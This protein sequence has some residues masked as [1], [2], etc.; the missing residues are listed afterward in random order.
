MFLFSLTDVF[1]CATTCFRIRRPFLLH[2]PAEQH[3]S[4]RYLAYRLQCN[5]LLWRRHRPDFE[6]NYHTWYVSCITEDSFFSSRSP[7]QSHI[8]PIMSSRAAIWIPKGQIMTLTPQ[9]QLLNISRNIFYIIFSAKLV[10]R[11][12]QIIW[13]QPNIRLKGTRSLNG[14][15][16]SKTAEKITG[17]LFI[18]KF[19]NGIGRPNKMHSWATCGPLAACL[20]PMVR[21]KKGIKCFVS[22][23]VL[24]C[25]EC[26]S[27]SGVFSFDNS[28]TD[29]CRKL[30]RT[31]QDTDAGI[32]FYRFTIILEELHRG[33]CHPW[34]TRI[35]HSLLSKKLIF[36]QT[37]RNAFVYFVECVQKFSHSFM[38]RR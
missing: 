15:E 13:R 18:W 14:R 5:G 29:C 32:L 38:C 37:T 23:G 7:P 33:H 6:T 24:V 16:L 3:H 28:S 35:L 1:H 26:W 25:K 30:G 21:V 8:S 27:I 10:V 9:S 17:I 34:A 12:W 4:L 19:P 31:A 2:Q 36:R 22:C 11:Y 20:R